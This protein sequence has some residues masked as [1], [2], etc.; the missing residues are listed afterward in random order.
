MKVNNKNNIHFGSTMILA[1]K[2]SPEQGVK[3]AHDFKVFEASSPFKIYEQSV[4]EIDKITSVM[5]ENNHFLHKYLKKIGVKI[6]EEIPSFVYFAEKFDKGDI[7]DALV[8][9]RNYIHKTNWKV[10]PSLLD[11]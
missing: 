6:K 3:L 10:P 1:K 8:K 9:T 4:N 2:L 7:H 11:K 5:D